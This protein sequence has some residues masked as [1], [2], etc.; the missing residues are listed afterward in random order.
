MM[1]DIV[2]IKI[3]PMGQRVKLDRTPEQ[4]AVL[5]ARRGQI[6]TKQEQARHVAELSAAR[7]TEKHAVADRARH[8]GMK[9]IQIRASDGSIQDVWSFSSSFAAMGFENQ[10][11]AAAERFQGDWQTAFAGLQGQGFAPG[12]DG[13]KS[14]HG[15]H[16]A[17]VSAQA[18]LAACRAH[19]GA[20][21]YDFVVAISI[22]GATVTGITKDAGRHHKVVR[23]NIDAAFDDLDGFY[24]GIRRK[25]RTWAVVETL[26][27]DRAALIAKAEKAAR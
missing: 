23:A 5:E 22:Y 8:N 27:R 11:V 7:S 24:A 9:R 6:L 10:Q 13:G 26:I 25:D 20:R 16:L 2:P 21:S 3:I 12:V 14:Q 18:R 17:R 15:P 4:M 1:T 19:L